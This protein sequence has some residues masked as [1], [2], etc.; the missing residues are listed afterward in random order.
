MGI[1]NLYFMLAHRYC[2]PNRKTTLVV[3]NNFEQT[4]NF[5]HS[6][7]G[8]FI[9]EVNKMWY[10]GG[11]LTALPGYQIALTSCAK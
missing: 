4:L 1:I 2:D 7:F 11:A 5:K 6:L 10:L 9:H 3:Q 8:H